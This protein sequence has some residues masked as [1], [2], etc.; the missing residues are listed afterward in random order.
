MSLALRPSST[1]V[2]PPGSHGSQEFPAGV[3]NGV[4]LLVVIL[5]VVVLLVS[6]L[7]L[8]R[9]LDYCED[10]LF[11]LLPPLKPELDAGFR[12]QFQK[13]RLWSKRLTDR[14][15]FHRSSSTNSL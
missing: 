6:A 12:K 7:W 1:T 11:A 10:P 13:R 2:T 3:C 8:R 4:A 5:L 14:T 15:H 9:F